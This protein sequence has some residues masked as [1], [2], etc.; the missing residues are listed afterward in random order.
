MTKEVLDLVKEIETFLGSIKENNFRNYFIKVNE[1]MTSSGD[2]SFNLM[3]TYNEWIMVEDDTYTNT[4][5]Q[6]FL[7]IK[8]FMNTYE[9]THY[10]CMIDNGLMLTYVSDAND[11]FYVQVSDN[12]IYVHYHNSGQH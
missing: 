8:G 5:S 4:Y 3:Q 9:S 6:L 1:S 7:L 10:V 11:I 2:E 12:N